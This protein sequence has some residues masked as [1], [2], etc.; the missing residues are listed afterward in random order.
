MEAADQETNFPAVA[1]EAR[2]STA[3]LYNQPKL[4]GRIMHSRKSQTWTPST[5][6]DRELKL[7]SL[8]QLKFLTRIIAERVN[9]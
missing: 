8:V 3:R 1:S 6:S 5:E 2:V 9:A 4:R 7:I